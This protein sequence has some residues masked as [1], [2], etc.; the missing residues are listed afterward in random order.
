MTQN[1]PLY[2][3][4]EG[5]EGSGKSTQARLLAEVIGSSAVLT[6]EPGNTAVGSQLRE[7]LL[8]PNTVDL[9]PMAEAYLMAADRAQHITQV[10]RPNLLAGRH[11]ISD[12]TFISSIAYQGAGRGL[13]EDGILKLNLMN[14]GLIMPDVLFLIQPPSPEEQAR[15]FRGM[16]KV[17][18]RIEQA[19]RD[20]H[21]RLSLSF[22]QMP[23]FLANNSPTTGIHVITVAQAPTPKQVH[24]TICDSLRD[25]C[26]AKRLIC[27][28]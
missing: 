13:G 10:V 1:K 2:I 18:D 20:F 8:S 19:E 26:Q 15:R 14:I 27:P 21:A 3:G 17:L 4:F 11:V 24:Q 6:H 22:D 28:V 7:I 5:G 12:R 25:F 23:N 9:D 16:G